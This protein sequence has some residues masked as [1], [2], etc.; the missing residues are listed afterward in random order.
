M[1]GLKVLARVVAG[2]AGVVAAGVATNQVLD[3]GALSWNWAYAAFALALIAE[4]SRELLVSPPSPVPGAR[5][6]RGSLGVYLRQVR[7]SVSYMETL[8]VAT[9]SEFMLR[10]RQVYVDVSL[11]PKPTHDTAREPYVGAVPA[12]PHAVPGERRTLESFL[13]AGHDGG[14]VLAVIGG[15]GSGKTTLVRTTTLNLSTRTW[16]FW[17]RGPLPVLLYLRDHAGALPA[18][19]PP[20]LADVA[21]SAGWLA[22][23]IPAAWLERRLD[24]GGCVVLLDG[25]D[26]VADEEDRVRVVAWIRRQIE[27]HPRNRYVVTSRPH[28]YLSN[29]LPSAE[30]L[31]VRR[32]THEQI[33]RYLHGWYH[34]IE[35]RAAGA[36]GPAVKEIAAG[37]ADE[38]LARLRAAPGL[39]DLAANPLLLT[40]IANV[41]RYRGQLPAGRAA[42]YAE[43]CDVLLHRRQEARNLTD[44]TGLRGP[45]KERVVRH[46]AL[47]MMRGRVR[48]MAAMDAGRA[49]R[50]ALR[51][52]SGTVTPE[53]FLEEAR[54]SGLLVEREHGRYAFAHLTLQ[55]YL[56]AAQI[57]QH[58]PGPLAGHVD[59]PWWRETI[60]LWSAN[61]DAT[62][63]IEA[64]LASGTVR[65]LALAFDCAEQALQV[66]PGVRE[67]LEA[68]LHA[69]DAEQ[70]QDR[71]RLLAGVKAA[72]SLR[73][74][75]WLDENTAVCARPV[76]RD[77]YDMFLRDTGVRGDTWYGARGQAPSG[78]ASPSG[79]GDA[80]PRNGRDMPS[81]G[82]QD[83]P[84]GA[85]GD[86]PAMGVLAGH[87]HLFVG[88]LNDLLD[89]DVTYR[90]PTLEEMGDPA[91]SLVAGVSG[92][93]VWARGP[94]DAGAAGDPEPSEVTV[95]ADG[96]VLHQPVGVASPYAPD[97]SRLVGYL[98]RDVA[99]CGDHLA[100]ALGAEPPAEVWSHTRVF[101][102]AL[103]YVETPSPGPVRDDFAR[104]LVLALRLELERLGNLVLD[105]APHVRRAVVLSRVMR[106]GQA[107]GLDLASHVG[108]TRFLTLDELIGSNLPGR[109]SL[110]SRELSPLFSSAT[111]LAPFMEQIDEVLGALGQVDDLLDY[112]SLEQWGV[113]VSHLEE[114]LQHAADLAHARR[115]GLMGGDPAGE[116]DRAGA[117]G[118]LSGLAGDPA[119]PPDALLDYYDG[120]D[121]SGGAHDLRR[122]LGLALVMH[123]ERFEGTMVALRALRTLWR[124]ARITAGGGRGRTPQ[125]GP[126]LTTFNRT[127]FDRALTEFSAGLSFTLRHRGNPVATLRAGIAV[128][129]VNTSPASPGHAESL[130]GRALRLAEEAEQLIAPVLCGG[131]LYNVID[132]AHARMR[133]LAA[134]TLLMRSDEAAE[135][136]TEAMAGL[137]GLQ[138]RFEGRLPANELIVLV[139]S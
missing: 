36:T 96:V 92:H 75:I 65:A 11:M 107:L 55:E 137:A 46:L 60:L 18:A 135:R 21:T 26:E 19:Q 2:A 90:L 121:T 62:P 25:L 4:L 49:I 44:A 53:V 8:G 119:H 58:D 112:L 40:M 128:L 116:F 76:S 34:A 109:A 82:R 7:A 125:G 111:L 117:L 30:V 63:V 35:S 78:D 86:G 101:A 123:D 69:G 73:E 118:R 23:R 16:R 124:P 122:A 84:P 79:G 129:S 48:D 56:A 10:T 97:V 28:G 87:T 70:D 37:K 108:L 41:H 39:Y 22:G 126:P 66:D 32:F 50:G 103:R 72:R 52:V 5:P 47:A 51:Q 15:P 94:G 59:D 105:R 127:A 81:A 115:L 136:L 67:R 3:N 106:L 29:P 85:A 132:F 13:A 57:G 27:R 110:D 138:E 45:Q 130:Y 14:R 91:L 104:V 64:C 95:T 20:G 131:A 83:A 24:R 114:A 80:P 17:R 93:T 74:V 43:M 31:Q 102:A 133:L 139:R 120:S 68:L 99:L 33:T 77:L 1:R 61:A 100:L 12:R 42:L 134:V 6:P 9:Q 54:K 89:G 113:I 88:W 98:A 71:R 38:L